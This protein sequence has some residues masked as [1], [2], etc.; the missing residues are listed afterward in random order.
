MFV[1]A[2]TAPAIAGPTKKPTLSMMPV[3][4]FAAVSSAG[5]SA[6]LGRMAAEAA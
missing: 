2:S 6:R 1:A 3:T 5:V 4:A